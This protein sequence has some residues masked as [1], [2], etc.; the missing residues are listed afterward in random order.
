MNS[1]IVGG[2]LERSIEVIGRAF[3]G[4][5]EKVEVPQELE[6]GT[7][8]GVDLAGRV[9]PASK[10]LEVLGNCTLTAAIID[11]NVVN[12]VV[13]KHP[14]AGVGRDR[15]STAPTGVVQLD[16]ETEALEGGFDEVGA[17]P[18]LLRRKDE[19]MRWE[20]QYAALTSTRWKG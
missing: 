9:E 13:V 7:S 5:G 6:R 4:E 16:T 8:L 18:T 3:G 12:A 19:R 17:S 11:G 15:K 2:L 1:S 20:M 14:H 10:E